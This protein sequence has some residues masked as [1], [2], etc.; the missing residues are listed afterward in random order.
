MVYVG[1]VDPSRAGDQSLLF[2]EIDHLLIIRIFIV[3]VWLPWRCTADS[4]HHVYRQTVVVHGLATFCVGN[5][6]A[7]RG[8]ALRVK[9]ILLRFCA[10]ALNDSELN[11]VC[12]HLIGYLT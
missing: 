2:A 7:R 3:P 6:L 8:A 1:D 11:T 5:D 4:G 10:E 9:S 12:G